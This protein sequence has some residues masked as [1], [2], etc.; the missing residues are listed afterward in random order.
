MNKKQLLYQKKLKQYLING[1]I[2]SSEAETAS[3]MAVQTLKKQ[4]GGFQ[5]GHAKRMAEWML[6]Q[7]GKVDDGTLTQ[8]EDGAVYDSEDGTHYKGN[9]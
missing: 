2:D 5:I 4:G 1:G 8:T 9:H 6:K 3:K 7:K